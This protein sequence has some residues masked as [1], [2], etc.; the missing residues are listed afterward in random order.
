VLVAL[1]D[2]PGTAGKV[3]ELR[4]GTADVLEATTAAAR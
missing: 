4:E 1:L 2:T 3:L